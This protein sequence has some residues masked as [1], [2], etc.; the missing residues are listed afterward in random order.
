MGFHGYPNQP[1][2]PSVTP[3]PQAPSFQ[4]HP[5]SFP[6]A[7]P[8]SH[9]GATP[10][11][12]PGSAPPIQPFGIAPQP[13]PGPFAQQPQGGR[14][15]PGQPQQAPLM[16]P[17][18]M[19]YNHNQPQMQSPTTA[20]PNPLTQPPAA[21]AGFIP[22]PPPPPIQNHR[23]S[24]L[25]VP[26]AT[27]TVPMASP[28]NGYAANHQP[29]PVPQQQQQQSGGMVSAHNTP[30]SA[31]RAGLPLPPLPNPPV[32][33]GQ[34]Q[35]QQPQVQSSFYMGPPAP[36]AAGLPG[37]PPPLPKPPVG[38]SQA[39]YAANA[40]NFTPQQLQPYQGGQQGPWQLQ[41]QSS[42]FVNGGFGQPS[43]TPVPQAGIYPPPPQVQTPWH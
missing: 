30:G 29:L 35:G 13:T 20:H 14:P 19:P 36:N 38:A 25:P 16:F 31:G 9:T 28:I 1:I 2:Y 5:N 17:N 24:S 33:G 3:V 18:A 34:A 4:H 42:G 7:L 6:S 32:G 43:H 23:A 26:A 21:S 27:N 15:L 40:T 11:S 37:P 10:L 22:P 41:P 8:P 39:P 12:P